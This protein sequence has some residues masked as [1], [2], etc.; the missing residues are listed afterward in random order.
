MGVKSNYN[1]MIILELFPH[2]NFN[3]DFCYQNVDE[4]PDYYNENKKLFEKTKLYYL[5]LFFE[6]YKTYNISNIDFLEMWGGELFYDNSPEYNKL[7]LDI[8][9]LVN[10]QKTLGMTSNLSNIN[11]ALNSLLFDKQPFELEISGSFD[12]I[13]RFHS[14]EMLDNF[15]KNVEI[16]KTS[17]NLNNGHMMIETVLLPEMLDDK[18][19]FTYFDK[20]YADEKIDNALNLDY[21]GYPDYILENF[22]ERLLKLLKKYPKLD[23]SLNFLIFSGMLNDKKKTPA[24]NNLDRY[25]FCVRN[26]SHYFS[27]VTKFDKTDNHCSSCKKDD[28]KKIEEAFN[29]KNCQYNNICSDVCPGAFINGRLTTLKNCPYAYIYDNIDELKKAYLKTLDKK[30]LM[31]F[32]ETNS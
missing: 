31:K 26:N 12:G 17:P 32:L 24:K 19:D 8:I 10:P 7:L 13:G 6:K 14:K 5:K 25:C 16:I 18:Y 9:K 20:L 28:Y 11:P 23:N 30:E 22:G 3:C 2:C 27:Y 4:R 21:R 1:G 29:C 15:F